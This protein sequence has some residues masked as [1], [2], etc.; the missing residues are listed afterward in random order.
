VLKDFKVMCSVD[1]KKFRAINNNEHPERLNF[2][3]LMLNLDT[4]NRVE[5]DFSELPYSKK[6]CQV[7]NEIMGRAYLVSDKLFSHVV[8]DNLEVRTSVAI[9]PATGAAEEGALYI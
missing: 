9:S 7:C 1:D 8:N 3:W 4:Q 6:L 2:G 5:I